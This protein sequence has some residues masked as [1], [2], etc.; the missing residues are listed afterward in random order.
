MVVHQLLLTFGRLN[1]LFLT[2]SNVIGGGTF[3][4]VA[5]QNFLL[6]LEESGAEGEF[7]ILSGEPVGELLEA[8]R[9]ERDDG[10]FSSAI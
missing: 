1:G 8:A 9:E 6:L 10:I 4:C 5:P 3:L 7:S 2:L